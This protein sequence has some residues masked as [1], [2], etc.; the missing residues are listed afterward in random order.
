MNISLLSNGFLLV[1][2]NIGQTFTTLSKMPGKKR[3]QERDLVCQP[4]GINLNY[5]LELYADAVWDEGA[6]KIRDSYIQLRM[7]EENSRQDKMADLTD[8]SGYE[9]K[10]VPRAH[11]LKAFILARD[12]KTWAHFHAPR[13]GKT[14]L[15]IDTAAYLFEKGEID[16]LIVVAP[17]GVHSN[18]VLN[19]V[20]T[21]MPDRI[22]YWADWY[23]SHK[24][25]KALAALGAA[26]L[27]SKRKE[28]K[29]ICFNVDGFSSVKAFTL[30]EH[31]LSFGSALMVIDESTRISNPSAK[32]TKTLI[33]F[34]EMAEY[35]RILTG[36]PITRGI[37]NLYSQFLFL[38]SR[39]LGHETFTTFRSQYCI[40]GGFEFRAIVGYKETKQLIKTIDGHS[41]RVT[42]EQCVDLPPKIYRRRPFELADGQRK[43]YDAFRKNSLAEIQALLGDEEGLK[44]AKEIAIVKLLR[45]QQIACHLTPEEQPK[46]LDGVDYRMEAL[47]EEIEEASAQGTKVIIWSRFT[48]CL[49]N[50]YSLLGDKAVRYYGEVK[51]AERILAQKRFQN[52]DKIR[53]L[54]GHTQA[55]GI[56]LDFSAAD[57]TIYHSNVS[58][59][60][61]RI[62]SEERCRSVDSTRKGVLFVDIEGIRTIDRKIINRLRALK[63]LSDEVLKDPISAFLEDE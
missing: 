8:D 15:T 10:T 23:S 61:L 41:D 48:A 40:M 46:P 12:K 42:S 62:Q 53:Y 5:L 14:K 34:G 30:L 57:W 11:Q 60:E 17:N 29:I 55:A 52:D 31:W 54:V 13:T 33:K 35:R 7:E 20:P 22:P 28:L 45:M 51:E 1:K 43:M 2:S 49:R 24:S 6:G 16:R 21:H 38:D 58:S 27:P 47:M 3:W 39:I 63:S 56:G 19:E 36:Y 18:W 37:E 9:F 32:R 25:K 59:L 50:I 4:S 44:R 26:A